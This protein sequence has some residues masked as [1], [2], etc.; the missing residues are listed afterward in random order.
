[1]KLIIVRHGQTCSNAD[2]IIQGQTNSQLSELGKE[3]A[4]KLKE[5]LKDEKI[6]FIFSSDLDR[7]RHTA[8]EVASIF[9]MKVNT[10]KLLRERSFGNLEGRKR[11]DFEGQDFYT[12]STCE[13]NESIMKRARDFLDSIQKY[14][15]KIILVVGHGGINIALISNL[16]GKSFKEAVE[17]GR[18]HNT[19]VSI[20]ED[21]KMICF[22]C[23]K[24]LE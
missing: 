20:F 5:R 4:K 23:T 6:D 11:S 2:G 3:Q 14:N 15:N 13:Q 22:N 16:L 18:H 9:R 24:H 21:G 7:A 8:E 17:M 10:T 19:G 1:M 12:F